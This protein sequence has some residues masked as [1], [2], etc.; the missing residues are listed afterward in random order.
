[1]KSGFKIRYT[2]TTETLPTRLIRTDLQRAER[3]PCVARD[4]APWQMGF[5]WQTVFLMAWLFESL[6]LI[7]FKSTQIPRCVSPPCWSHSLLSLCHILFHTFVAYIYSVTLCIYCVTSA[8]YLLCHQCTLCCHLI[9]AAYLACNV[10]GLPN[11]LQ[12]LC[13]E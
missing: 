13:W 10:Y 1:M 11:A 3:C 7:H 8:L 12:G 5:A 2:F 9:Q 6:L 4:P